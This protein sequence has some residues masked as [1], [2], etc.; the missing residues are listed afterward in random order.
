MIQSV[1]A[2]QARGKS[3]EDKIFGANNRANA[4][5]D[6][7]GVDKV[8]NGTVGSI[9]DEDGQ[10]VMLKVVQEAF[11]KLTPKEIVSYAPIQ[12]YPDYLEAVINQCFGQS[13]PA[14]YLRACATSGGSGVLHHVIHN[15]SE[16]GDEILTSDYHWGAY[17]SMCH[18][19]GRTLREF[20]LLDGQ[21]HFNLAS[22]KEHVADMVSKQYN[23]V[24]IINS[25]AN[26]P[27]GF[28]LTSEDWDNVLAFLKDVVKGKN[29]NIIL[30]PDVAYLDYSGEKQE[31]RKFFKKFGNL[32]DNIL[33]IVAYTCSKGFTMYGQRM[34]AMICITP[35]KYIADEFVAINQYT[36]RATWSNS[37]SAAMKAMVNICKDPAKVV[38]LDG[39]RAK[40]FNLIKARADIFMDEAQNCGLMY[41]PYLSGFFITIPMTHSQQ[42]C[43]A[44]EKENI[45]LVPLKKGIRLA[46]CSVSKQKITGLAKK[47]KEAVDTAGA[48]QD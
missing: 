20:E 17:G 24:I 43:D 33:V 16:W 18:D 47:I 31:C 34:G 26:N 21:G 36:S 25:P 23:T 28:A 5:A 37:N 41:L 30:V 2:P 40:Y 29:K 15:Y 42:V 6:K 11:K 22:F 8:I 1:A 48:K 19:N 35:N 14:G 4:L 7:I 38:E 12:G 45:F 44:L 3:A 10:L 39:E 13:R 27:T 46:V 9:L 32:L